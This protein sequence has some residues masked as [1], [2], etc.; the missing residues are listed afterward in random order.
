MYW[1]NPYAYNPA[2]AGLDN[3]LIA[4]GVY[5]QQWSG[6]KGAPVS[7]HVNAHMPLFF[8][9]SGVGLKIE[10]DAI[11]A[12]RTTAVLASYDYQMEIGKEAML[13]A[14]LSAGYLQ[15]VLDGDML[16]TPQGT[17]EQTTGVFDHNDP[18]LP[19][20]KVQAGTP[21]FEAGVFLRVRKLSA[22]VSVQPVFAPDIHSTASGS[23]RLKPARHYLMR[24]SYAINVHENL[25][26]EPSIMVKSDITETQSE[27]SVTMRYRENIFAGASLRGFGGSSKD[28]FVISGGLRLNDKTILAYAYDIP[29]SSLNT[30]NRGSHELLLRY[31]LNKTIG[32]G[33]LPPVIYNPRF[34]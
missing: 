13:S 17:Y 6:L 27:I 15:Y 1:L 3:T 21:V 14:G 33:K 9:N 26:L 11:G 7:Q 24:V 16:R 10:N 22:G 32:A 5:R 12:H 28:A 2:C 20:G 19:V 34:L 31:S 4:T 23:L 29:L 30:V 8:I 18:D 25:V